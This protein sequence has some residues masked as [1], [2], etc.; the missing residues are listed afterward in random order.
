MSIDINLKRSLRE[1]RLSVLKAILDEI[2]D[3]GF[4]FKGASHLDIGCSTGDFLELATKAGMQS[5]GV[6]P[7]HKFAEV[8]RKRNLSVKAGV[9]PNKNLTFEKK[10][11][12]ISFMDVIGH[13]PDCQNALKSGI[14]LL[15]DSGKS[16]ILIKTPVSEGLFFKLAAGMLYVNVDRFWRR[17][18]QVDFASP[19]IHYFSRKSLEVLATRCGMSIKIRSR[20][21]ITFKGLWARLAPSFPSGFVIRG[22]IYCS[23]LICFPF[24]KMCPADSVSAELKRQPHG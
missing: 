6:E 21:A 12:L 19:Q 13:I 10:F 11:D 4:D 5:E 9:F 17:I 8:A 1:V 24:I 7:E 20:P 2:A 23:L 3:V 14:S 22:L 16:R 15:G 18:W